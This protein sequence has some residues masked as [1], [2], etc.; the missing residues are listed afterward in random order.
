MGGTSSK[1]APA[2]IETPA[3]ENT[4][5]AAASRPVKPPG[6][7]ESIPREKLPAELQKIID[8]EETLFEQL[9]DGK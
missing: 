4:V 3:K 5:T 9:Y 1:E 6:R 8:D 2:K 7:D